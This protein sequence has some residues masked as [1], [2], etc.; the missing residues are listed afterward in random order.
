M[1]YCQRCCFASGDV[2]NVSIFVLFQEATTFL[3]HGFRQTT[4]YRIRFLE[5]KVSSA[6]SLHRVYMADAYS[7]KL[8]NANAP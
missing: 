8:G 5:V 4:I 2:F 6:K 1:D 3:C 7:K